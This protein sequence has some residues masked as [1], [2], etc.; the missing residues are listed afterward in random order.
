MIATESTSFMGLPFL[1]DRSIADLRSI[2]RTRFVCPRQYPAHPKASG[3]LTCARL[4]AVV[5][6]WIICPST[7][8]NKLTSVLASIGLTIPAV[9]VVR[10]DEM[11]RLVNLT[12]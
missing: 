1:L 5:P 6:H 7:Y 9:A 8:D 3:C 2:F 10:I 11:K 4:V 12:W